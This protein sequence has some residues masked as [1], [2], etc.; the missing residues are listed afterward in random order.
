LE[1]GQEVTPDQFL[2]HL[3]TRIGSDITCSGYYR[4]LYSFQVWTSGWI[5]DWEMTESCY[6]DC[7]TIDPPYQSSNAGFFFQPEDGLWSLN[8]LYQNTPENYYF[9]D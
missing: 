8:L 4:D 6:I 1:G 5:P 3:E 2:Q 7:Q 9:M